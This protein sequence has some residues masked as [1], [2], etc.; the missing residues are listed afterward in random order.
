M[1]SCS[2]YFTNKKSFNLVDNITRHYTV[3]Q[4]DC[5]YPIG[6]PEVL[7][8]LNEVID[9]NIG[10]KTT[11]TYRKPAALISR[12]ARGGKT[13]VLAGLF[14]SLQEREMNSIYVSFNGTSGFERL[15]SETEE[16]ALFR[17]IAKQFTKSDDFKGKFSID[18]GS[19][20]EYIGIRS[21]C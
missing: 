1:D 17:V 19:I 8:R 4:T 5:K 6:L 10:L 14:R 11:A 12:L 20:D 2:D 9:K 3:S 21:C 7:A 13:T 15:P 16:A 18:W